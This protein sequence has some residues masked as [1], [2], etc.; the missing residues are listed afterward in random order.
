MVCIFIA[1]TID[2]LVSQKNIVPSYSFALVLHSKKIKMRNLFIVLFCLA[3]SCCFLTSCR[4]TQRQETQKTEIKSESTYEN[5]VS[6]TDTILYSPKAE[7]GFK[8]PMRYLDFKSDLTGVYRPFY[9][10]QKNGQATA[11][12][13]AVNDTIDVNCICDTVAIKAKIK[14]ELQKLNSNN[15][16]SDE[17]MSDTK[18]TSGYSF[19]ELLIYS[20]AAFAIGFIVCFILK[21]FKIL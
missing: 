8:I 19:L 10:T 13:K 2:D 18:V 7:T 3:F 21:T 14:K 15:S 9:Y 12:F 5:I 11:K 16:F 17:K 1:F 4:S 6:Y 20:I